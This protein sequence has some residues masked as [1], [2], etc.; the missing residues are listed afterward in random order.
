MARGWCEVGYKGVLNSIDLFDDFKCNLILISFRP[1][2]R[3]KHLKVETI[4]KNVIKKMY[5][6]IAFFFKSK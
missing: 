2:K 1:Q 3:M 6:K 5:Y 4:S